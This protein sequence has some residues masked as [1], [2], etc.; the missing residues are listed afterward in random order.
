M[1]FLSTPRNRL[2]GIN[3]AGLALLVSLS[4]A[5]DARS[6][7]L[8]NDGFDPNA[9]GQVTVLQ[10]QPDG[11][12][13]MGGYFTQLHPFGTAIS[14]HSYVARLNHDGTADSSFTP[15]ANNVVNAMVLQPNGQIIIS[16]KFTTIQP[17]GSS[18]P[19][20]RNYVARLNADGTLD[21]VF[22]PN[23]NGVVYAVAYQPNGQIIIGGG[24]TTVQPN[25]SAAPEPHRA[26]QRRW[27]A[28]HDLQPE[29]GQDGPLPCGGPD[30]PDPGWRRILDCLAQRRGSHHAQL[31]SPPQRGRFPRH[32]L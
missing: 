28:R 5:V 27:L 19:V 24:F 3:F 17:T 29:Y 10:L 31:R 6:L 18:T 32:R 12:I 1:P 2:S 21:P 15:N 11:K 8:P 16:G 14:G 25:G 30:G 13:L 22:N 20:T 26:V 9:N 4:A 23:T 7:T